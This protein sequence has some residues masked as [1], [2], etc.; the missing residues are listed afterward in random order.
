M[1]NFPICSACARGY[2]G[3]TRA[4]GFVAPLVDLG[5]RLYVAWVFLKSG[6]V[7]IQSWDSTLALFEY[8]YAVPLL[9]FEWAAYLGTAAELTLPALLI[10]G[11]FGHFAA[12]ALFLLNVMAVVSYPD[13]SE[14]GLQQHLYWGMLL[15]F[16]AVHGPG[17]LAIDTWLF[18]DR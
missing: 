8:E 13:L 10:L 12:L 3:F 11:L 14:V 7:K 4:L 1:T 17:K 6:L 18:R 9:P 16:L 5:L 15:A 2:G